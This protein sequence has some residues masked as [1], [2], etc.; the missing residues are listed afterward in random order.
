MNVKTAIS[1]GNRK[2]ETGQK[3]T[4]FFDIS[5]LKKNDK[6][7]VEPS[8]DI[9]HTLDIMEIVANKYKND[10]QL[11]SHHLK[12]LNVI[13]TLKNIHS[14]VVKNIQYTKDTIGIEQICRPL[15]LWVDREGKNGHTD[16]DCM[17]VFISSILINLEIPHSFRMVGYNGGDFQ[18]VY[19]VVPNRP[20]DIILDG[21]VH[22]FNI[23][24]PYTKKFDK[25]VNMNYQILDGLPSMNRRKNKK[26]VT[27]KNLTQ[28]KKTK[29][30]T[31][32]FVS[33][34]TKTETDQNIQLNNKKPIF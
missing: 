5:Q 6:I 18:H 26:K 33:P 23:E 13:Q 14:F 17:S 25:K 34:Y 16:C 15:R 4:R 7:I 12:G 32:N 30:C 11:I 2:I 20:Q 24:V 19:V 31:C 3:Y 22:Q 8:K 28:G 9:Y 29:Q 21:V 1:Y 10:T 27:N